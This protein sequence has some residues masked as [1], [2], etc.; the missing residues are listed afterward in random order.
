MSGTHLDATIERRG[1]AL[2]AEAANR[3]SRRT[4]HLFA[5]ILAAEWLA[6]VAVAA[7]VSPRAWA[8]EASWIH[9]HVW[10]AVFLGGGIAAPAA[11]L[12]LVRPGLAS[13]RYVVAAAQML[14][15]SLLIHLTGGRIETHFHI[16]GSLALL[17]FYRDWRV[18]AVATAIVVADHLIRGAA[19]PRSIFGS[20]SA[21][22]W[23]WLEH[24][25]WVAFEDAFLIPHCLRGVAEMREVALRRAELEATRAGVESLVLRRT[26][27]LRRANEELG[28]R[29]VERARVQEELRQGEE[30]FRGAFDAAAI[31][32]ALVA[33]DGRWLR[34]NRAICE[35]LGYSEEEL[36]GGKT[37]QDVTHPDD[38]EADLAQA[39]R[40]LAG[41]V[42][43][44]QLEKRYVHKA[45]HDVW[46]VLGVSLVRD[47]EGRPLHFVS[48]VQDVTP[49]RLAESQ[50]RERQRFVESVNEANPSILYIYDVRERR[51]V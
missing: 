5:G 29:D 30:R 26:A 24:A 2:Y 12:A 20:A 40:M 43:T 33:P 9:P 34:V 32:M 10:A 42:R 16:F 28:L 6:T 8:G 3:V 4:D 1:S 44:Y 22:S 13:T 51:N 21:P 7:W 37:F 23:R 41:E 27:E 46:V 38:V 19:W 35:I 48:Q 49:R 17:A 18:L 25:A 50:L 47:G 45:G 39:G 14:M 15:G 31:G 11:L 36:L